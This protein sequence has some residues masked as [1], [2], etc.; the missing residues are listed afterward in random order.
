[1]SHWAI[2]YIGEPWVR[3]EHDCWAFFRRVQAERFGRAIPEIPVENYRRAACVALIEGHAERGNWMPT[4]MPQEGDA[5]L[6]SHARHPSHV[7]V[8]V[9]VDGGG[10]LHCV[11]GVGV[12]F[13][14]VK[15]LKAMGWGRLEYYRHV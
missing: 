2:P 12:C 7:G 8:W 14:T 13:Q 10:V 1:M 6:L 5:V 9:E 11:G 3:H 15:S 4:E